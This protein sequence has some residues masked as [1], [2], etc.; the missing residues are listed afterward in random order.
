M[1]NSY[2]EHDR[3][4]YQPIAQIKKQEPINHEVWVNESIYGFS[5]K[6][7]VILCAFP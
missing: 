5:S 1:P 2:Q 7:I 4:N 6:S 3:K